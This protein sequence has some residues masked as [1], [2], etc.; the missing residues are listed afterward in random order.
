[1]YKLH[2]YKYKEKDSG[3]SEALELTGTLL[4]TTYV[5]IKNLGER[6]PVPC[7]NNLLKGY[8]IC[9][10]FLR[11]YYSPIRPPEVQFA[12]RKLKILAK[13]DIIGEFLNL[14][15]NLLKCCPHT[16]NGNILLSCI[17]KH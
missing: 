11:R 15:A 17:Y 2:Q 7:I 12:K 3:M 6:F 8:T 16:V 13:H 14:Y 5:H 9:F 10:I 1:M 4:N